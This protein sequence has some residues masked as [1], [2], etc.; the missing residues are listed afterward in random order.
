MDCVLTENCLV[1]CPD[2]PRRACQRERDLALKPA[3]L[4]Q[5]G[6]SSA[7]MLFGQGGERI[8]ERCAGR[9]AEFWEQAMQVTA[10]GP[11]G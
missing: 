11:V 8:T 9:D 5:V 3:A 2:R 6:G 4:T 10:D 7:L 1:R